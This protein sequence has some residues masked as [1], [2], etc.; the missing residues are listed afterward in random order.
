[1]AIADG[2]PRLLAI[3]R[4]EAELIAAGR[5]ADLPALED[6]RRAAMAGLPAQAPIEAMAVLEEAHRLVTANVSALRDA[7][8][9]TPSAPSSTA[10]AC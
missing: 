8:A 3:A 6:E 9:P 2:Y 7:V 10:T 1:V 5:W 4:R